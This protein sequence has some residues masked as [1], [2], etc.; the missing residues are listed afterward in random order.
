KGDRKLVRETLQQL[1]RNFG[2]DLTVPFAKLPRKAREAVLFG[3]SAGKN[4]F[5]GLLPNLRRRYDAGSWAEQEELE[6]YRSLRPCPTCHGERLKTQSLSVKVKSRTISD[7]V[8]LPIS[9]ALRVFDGLQLTDRDAL[10]ADR[11]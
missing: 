6:P 3:G 8:N 2:V 11:I 4:Q 9:E 10:I 5:E 1:S 7:Y